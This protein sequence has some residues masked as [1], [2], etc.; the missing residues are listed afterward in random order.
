[1]LYAFDISGILILR[2]EATAAAETF[3]HVVFEAEASLLAVDIFGCDGM[4]AGAQGVE[5]AYKG[6]DGSSRSN[7]GI[8]AEVFRAIFDVVVS[9]EN[10]R[11]MFFS[12][13]DPRVR[14]VV[15]EEDVVARFILLNHGVFEVEGVLL[16][17]D[18]DIRHIG[19]GADEQVGAQRLVGAVEI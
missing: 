7:V 3:L 1:L 17:W 9:E 5:L 15:F 12:D 18:D 10:S 19:D 2:D 16:G 6:E 13:A 14:F 8:R 11:E 4:A